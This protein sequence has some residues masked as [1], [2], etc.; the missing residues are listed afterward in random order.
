VSDSSS[1]QPPSREPRRSFLRRM[2]VGALGVTAGV[3]GL[4]RPASAEVNPKLVHA[5]CCTL[6]YTTLCTTTQWNGCSGRWAWTCCGYVG[7]SLIHV[8][9][10]E[11]DA[12]KCSGYAF[13][14]AC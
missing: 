1:Q 3:V 9:C 8:S 5:Y 6:S 2:A 12:K 4:Q 11:C 13:G 10:R 7:S 14:S